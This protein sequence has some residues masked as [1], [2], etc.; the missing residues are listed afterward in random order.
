MSIKRDGILRVDGRVKI[1]TRI[2]TQMKIEHVIASDA[3]IDAC[4]E[5]RTE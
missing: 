3:L 1:S 4:T 2:N 5:A